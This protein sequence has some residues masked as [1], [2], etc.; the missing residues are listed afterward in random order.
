VEKK[1]LTIAGVIEQRFPNY[2]RLEKKRAVAKRR[3]AATELTAI[4]FARDRGE[5]RSLGVTFTEV[6][7]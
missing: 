4:G 1:R 6:D 3:L 5:F 2:A 7:P